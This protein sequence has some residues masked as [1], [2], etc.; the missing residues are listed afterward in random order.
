MSQLV[1]KYLKI[2]IQSRNSEIEAAVQRFRECGVEIER[3]SLVTALDGSVHL[4]V[5][6]VDR[7]SWRIGRPGHDIRVPI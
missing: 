7:S 2:A 1:N 3:F 4:F 6:G 5:D